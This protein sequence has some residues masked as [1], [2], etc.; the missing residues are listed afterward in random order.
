MSQQ[1]ILRRVLAA[2]YTGPGA[3]LVDEE[4]HASRERILFSLAA[5]TIGNTSTA[6]SHLLQV[7]DRGSGLA[8][9]ETCMRV[10]ERHVAAGLA[11]SSIHKSC[12]ALNR[13]RS[14]QRGL[15]ST[16][17][18]QELPRVRALLAEYKKSRKSHE[19]EE[20]DFNNAHTPAHSILT[21]DEL[22]N[23]AK[24]VFGAFPGD[25]LLASLVLA[26]MLSACAMGLRGGDDLA[27]LRFSHF[28][29]LAPIAAVGPTPMVPYVV[30]GKGGKTSY[31]GSTNYF[32]GIQHWQPE[33][34]HVGAMALYLAASWSAHHATV[35]AAIADGDDTWMSHRFFVIDNAFTHKTAPTHKWSALFK[36]ALSLLVPEK[37][38]AV[39]HIG[40]YTGTAM[41]V[42]AGLSPDEIKCWGRWLSESNDT[43]LRSYRSRC[44][45]SA[46]PALAATAGFDPA[47][48]R[49]R[50]VNHRTAVALFDDNAMTEA[51]FP[52]LGA[53][54]AAVAGRAG[55][56][57]AT[58]VLGAL[59]GLARVFWQN[60]PLYEQIYG[61]ER[62]N[63]MWPERVHTIRRRPEYGAFVWTVMAAQEATRLSM[64]GP[65]LPHLP[66]HNPTKPVI[67]E[68]R[69]KPE[70]PSLY[71]ARVKTVEEAYAEHFEGIGGGLAVVDRVR[72]FQA[73]GY[74]LGKQSNALYS[75]APLPEAL[76]RMTTSGMERPAAIEVVKKLQKRFG[77][78]LA[79]LRSALSMARGYYA[80]SRTSL[81]SR[82]KNSTVT[83]EDVAREL[84]K[85]R[86]RELKKALKP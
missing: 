13:I 70:M 46:V 22:L 68:P 85:R 57:R 65:E 30:A 53:A 19:M 12:D 62:W 63:G 10:V 5:N 29:R 74:K 28:S 79:S 1:D 7:G 78:T 20:G 59:R 81:S 3:S 36:R 39:L 41:L 16:T 67:W 64:R 83:L 82:V 27:N 49:T 55:Q 38:R 76:R 72:A 60:F 45:V 43:A 84:R 69:L 44:A 56:E 31:N 11:V 24:G 37:K 17:K 15:P 86:Y 6:A 33:L 21:E 61:A 73:Q 40:R 32:A 42:R 9:D 14:V 35:I 47:A 8:T 51:V 50:H 2:S 75:N 80:R 4:A 52:G 58:E 54:E 26:S 66:V 34:D 23:F 77:F 71:S 18:V 25:P 48:Y